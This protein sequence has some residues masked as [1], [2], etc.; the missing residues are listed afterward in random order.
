MVNNCGRK[1]DSSAADCA[2]VGSGELEMPDY[3]ATYKVVVLAALAGIGQRQ[4]RRTGPKIADFP[5]KAEAIEALDKGA[6]IQSQ[7]ALNHTR[8][9]GASGIG[10]VIIQILT[11]AE[12][13]ETTAEANPG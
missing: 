4:I 6:N 7:S 11:L 12:V 3:A 1:N 8:I 13:A 2:P 9:R 10:A 5:T